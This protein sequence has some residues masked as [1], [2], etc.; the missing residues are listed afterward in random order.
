M[1]ARREIKK[2]RFKCWSDQFITNVNKGDEEREGRM[3]LQVRV[4]G[5]GRKA[6]AKNRKEVRID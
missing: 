3:L 5:E 1:Y 6:I 4:K 2:Q